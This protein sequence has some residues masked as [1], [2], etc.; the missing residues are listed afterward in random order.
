MARFLARLTA[1][2]LV[3]TAGWFLASLK[4][5]DADPAVVAAIKLRAEEVLSA[6][7][8]DKPRPGY[9]EATWPKA[10]RSWKIDSVEIAESRARICV[11]V[12]VIGE[13]GVSKPE[14]WELFWK[15]RP[16]I[17][18]CCTRIRYDSGKTTDAWKNW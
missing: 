14:R 13:G 8:D 9:Q 16:G 15:D 18:W 10:A 5:E 11:N 4:A 7:R 17:G 12:S 6:A 1:I 2:L 3:V